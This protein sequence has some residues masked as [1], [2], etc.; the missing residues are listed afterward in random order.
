MHDNDKGYDYIKV[1]D[2]TV[3]AVNRYTGEID[4]AI[5]VTVP[6][7]TTF[8]TPQQQEELRNRKERE[9]RRFFAKTAKGVKFYFVSRGGELK[10]MSPETVAR[11]IYLISYIRLE[12]NKQKDNL[13]MWKRRPMKR[14]DLPSVLSVSPATVT[15]FWSEVYPDYISENNEGLLFNNSDLFIK[16]R[17][18]TKSSLKFFVKGIQELYRITPATKHRYLGYLFQLLPYVNIEYN[19]LCHNPL[20]TELDE[21]EPMS[22]AEFCDLIDY[23]KSNLSR[24]LKVY[25]NL[26]FSTDGQQSERFVSFVYDGLNRDNAK[27]FIN[28]NILYSGTQGDKVA[29]LGAFCQ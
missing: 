22:L 26:R 9:R 23:D 10:G 4:D 13:L 5:T 25:R 6:R 2:G 3:K 1:D 21:I 14:E 20:E 11:L 19:I 27:V 8:L 16:G 12:E 24:L 7:G 18:L 17:G 28:P 29:V 15:K